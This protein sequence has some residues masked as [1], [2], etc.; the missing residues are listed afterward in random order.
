MVPENRTAP[1]TLAEQLAGFQP[2]LR[3]RHPAVM[4]V[5]QVLLH[6][7]GREGSSLLQSSRDVI[8]DWLAERAGRPLPDYAWKGE[9]FDLEDIGSQRVA[10]LRMDDGRYWAARLDD[11]D[12]K[13]PQ[14]TWVTEI[15]IGEHSS[16][17]VIFGA[18][19]TCVT[20]GRDEP[21]Q[22][23]LPAFVR[24]VASSGFAWLDGFQVKEQPWLIASEEDVDGLVALLRA[25]R[26]SDVIVLSL[27]EDSERPDDAAA[28]A[29]EICRGT[30][31]AAHV[32]ILTGPASFHLSDRVGKEF[33]VFHSA[34]RTYRPGFNPDNDEPFEHPLALPQ[35]IENWADGGPSAYARF[36]IDQ[37]LM[38]SVARSDAQDAVPPFA[39]V[40]QLAT[41][42]RLDLARQGVKTDKARLALA[43]EEI[44]ELR[45]S[46]DE[47]KRTYTEL[48]LT[49]EQER[50]EAKAAERAA[51]ALAASL[52]FRM[53]QQQKATRKRGA[54][55]PES[56]PIPK[57]LDQ[58]DQW[59]ARW[60]AGSVEVHGRAYQGIKKSEFQNIE[61]IYRALL[62]LRDWYVPMRRQGGS[63]AKASFEG[64]CHL[65]GL[66][67]SPTSS[68]ER[69]GEEGDTY[70]IRRAGRRR[71]LDRHLKNR[72]NT[73]DPRR[74]FRLYF[75][76]DEDT[77]Q[78]IVGWLPSHLDSRAT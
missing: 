72:G 35:R 47:Q 51:N 77:E 62:L 18:R 75:F 10:A 55:S 25:P 76:W 52:R 68:A 63:E 16:D 19:L 70:V 6:L 45:E 28:P 61:L 40:R 12:K 14:R 3:R 13:V 29:G 42:Q 36:L 66:E 32:A 33:S 59:C 56:I 43:E 26:R 22:R 2:Q 50:D 1:R 23:T 11:A 41:R 9:S 17:G 5:S 8:L 7:K 30:F 57:D 15:G 31:G 78:A 21:Y 73:R 48:L 67:E 74:C 60:L 53:D 27:P 4:P 24:R 44:R 54:G 37:S 69:M 34:V 58:I 71:L 20:R 64:Q 46:L 39:V 65:L 38:R 49:A